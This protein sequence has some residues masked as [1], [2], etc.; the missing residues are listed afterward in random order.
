[1]HH[2][3]IVYD[4][5]RERNENEGWQRPGGC[6]LNLKK[7]PRLP[8]GK[9]SGCFMTTRTLLRKDREVNVLLTI[10]VAHFCLWKGF[11]RICWSEEKR[12]ALKLRPK[13]TEAV[14]LHL[15]L[16]SGVLSTHDRNNLSPFHN[17]PTELPY[18]ADAE[19]SLSYDE[20]EVSESRR[21]YVQ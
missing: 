15:P 9:A 20:L 5:A 16:D 13:S 18:A 6:W 11:G 2:E 3:L 17:M 21:L 12:S 7:L 10:V 8:G 14:R 19:V 1:M 4:S